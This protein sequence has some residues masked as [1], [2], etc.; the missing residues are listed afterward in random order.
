MGEL[1][2]VQNTWLLEEVFNES[3]RVWSVD[4][5]SDYSPKLLPVKNTFIICKKVAKEVEDFYDEYIVD[6]PKLEDWQ[7]KD[8]V[9]STAQGV[10]IEDLDELIKVC[11]HDIFRINQEL[12]KIKLFDEKERKYA[13]KDFKSDGIFSDLSELTIFD[14]SSAIMKRDVNTIRRVLEVIDQIDVEPIGLQ[15]VLLNNFR[16]VILVQLNINPTPQYFEQKFGW[17]TG[18][19]WAIKYTCSYY[20]KEQLVNIFK[21]LTSIKFGDIPEDKLVSYLITHIMSM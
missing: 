18:K 11:N 10:D 5:L 14:L 20:T 8:F 19:F 9:Y 21:F 6:V 4:T 12:K 15:K 16:D 1:L 3:Y 7:I 13:F 17:K 2:P